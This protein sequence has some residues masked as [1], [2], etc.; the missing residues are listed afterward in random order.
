MEAPVFV[1]L[2]ERAVAR[3]LEGRSPGVLWQVRDPGQFLNLS[4]ELASLVLVQR[5]PAASV[6]SAASALL[7]DDALTADEHGDATYDVDLIRRVAS[8]ARVRAF[9]ATALLMLTRKAALRLGV[10]EWAKR[11]APFS[12]PL[13]IV[14]DPWSVAAEAWG[15]RTLEKVVE[16]TAKWPAS[17]KG[18]ARAAERERLRLMGAL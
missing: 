3:A 1:L 2:F 6:H 12:R 17:I 14:L 15:R 7:G 5:R 4:V 16:L 13:L 11:F 8:Y 18:E 10:L 9:A